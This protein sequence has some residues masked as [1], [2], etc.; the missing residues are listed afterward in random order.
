MITLIFWEVV[1]LGIIS[2]IVRFWLL[3]YLTCVA[4]AFWI[5]SLRV[6]LTFAHLTDSN[7]SFWASLCFPCK[8]ICFNSIS[9]MKQLCWG[10]WIPW[11]VF[12]IVVSSFKLLFQ[13]GTRRRRLE[14]EQ[15]SKTAASR[16]DYFS[17]FLLQFFRYIPFLNKQGI[18]DL[19]FSVNFTR[20]GISDSAH[21]SSRVLTFIR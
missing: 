8:P 2:D 5:M 4:N 6:Y 1:W 14:S 15:E 12:Q 3:A 16:W 9:F 18:S 7:F 21:F 10:W 20:L 19:P 11:L 17:I 13:A